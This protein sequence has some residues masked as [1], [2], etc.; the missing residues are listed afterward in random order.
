[1]RLFIFNAHYVVVN[2]KWCWFMGEN[3]YAEK[4][5][6]QQKQTHSIAWIEKK[7][8]KSDFINTIPM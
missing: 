2:G 3:R 1:M 4:N 5:A 7:K 6:A 8:K